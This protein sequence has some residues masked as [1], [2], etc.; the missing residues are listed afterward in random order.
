MSVTYTT[1]HSNT[2]SLT[3]CVRPVM[4]PT[5][6][7]S[8]HGPFEWSASGPGARSPPGPAPESQVSRICPFCGP[9]GWPPAP[10]EAQPTAAQGFLRKRL[11]RCRLRSGSSSLLTLRSLSACPVVSSAERTL[12][13]EEG[14]GRCLHFG[15]V[16]VVMVLDL[17]PSSLS[18]CST[19]QHS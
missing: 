7:W 10:R 6:L 2:R 4:E 13:A 18:F 17:A 16:V 19:T 1:A 8:H 14:M 3:H 15:G 5:T 12:E 11:G 9:K